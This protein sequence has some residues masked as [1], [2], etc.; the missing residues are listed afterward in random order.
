MYEKVK[1]V[2]LRGSV[3]PQ[4]KNLQVLIKKNNYDNNIIVHK[5][6]DFD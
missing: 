2:N 5:V 4:A 6:A 3:A 1:V